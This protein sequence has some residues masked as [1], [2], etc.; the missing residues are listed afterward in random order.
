MFFC[1]LRVCLFLYTAGIL[2][3]VECCIRQLWC[4]SFLSYHNITTHK[5]HTHNNPLLNNK[6]HINYIYLHTYLQKRWE[7]DKKKRIARQRRAEERGRDGETIT[8]DSAIGIVRELKVIIMLVYVV[9]LHCYLSMPLLP[10]SICSGALESPDLLLSCS[11]IT[12]E[13]TQNRH[14]V[15]LILPHLRIFNL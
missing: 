13:I 3:R 10:Y 14:T 15:I 4:S 8:Y 6:K 9:C 12:I 7:Q 2:I 1:Y 5:H 11:T